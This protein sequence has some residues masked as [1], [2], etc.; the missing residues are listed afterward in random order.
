MSATEIAQ[1][2]LN[3][4]WR[5]APA[6][7]RACQRGEWAALAR[8]IAPARPLLVGRLDHRRCLALAEAS[9][10]GPETTKLTL[11]PLWACSTEDA[12]STEWVAVHGVAAG[13]QPLSVQ[14]I[15]PFI[16]VDD[17]S[18]RA[19]ALW[20][21]TVR[22][23][24]AATVVESRSYAP[25]IP[26]RLRAGAFAVLDLEIDEVLSVEEHASEPL[27]RPTREVPMFAS[28]FEPRVQLP[29]ELEAQVR[30]MCF[31]AEDEDA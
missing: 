18:P 21:C 8:E 23:W 10:T 24:R 19:D 12:E 9:L 11:V 30:A 6:A 5:H 15:G 26:L 4:K 31:T 17:A 20:E 14:E 2:I 13:G 7:L 27:P 1:Q 3:G 29:P 16:A 28:W 22:R 25:G